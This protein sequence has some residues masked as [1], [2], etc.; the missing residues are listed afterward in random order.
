MITP[1]GMQNMDGR[2]VL[3]HNPT[4]SSHSQVLNLDLWV[5]KKTPY[6]YNQDERALAINDNSI[7]T[8][9]FSLVTWQ[10]L[11]SN[12]ASMSRGPKQGFEPQ[13]IEFILFVLE[14]RQFFSFGSL[15]SEK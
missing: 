15:R 10:R 4:Y 8:E 5:T 11:F 12:E 14:F 3:S 2:L 7:F 9:F 1:S 6:L 13:D